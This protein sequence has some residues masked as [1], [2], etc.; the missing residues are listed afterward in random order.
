MVLPLESLTKVNSVQQLKFLFFS[1]GQ[2]SDKLSTHAPTPINKPTNQ[3]FWELSLS[4]F[5][6]A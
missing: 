2:S 6:H 5:I 1:Y 4:S 3:Y